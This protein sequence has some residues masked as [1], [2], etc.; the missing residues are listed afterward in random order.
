LRAPAALFKPTPAERNPLS[1]IALGQGGK[2]TLSSGVNTSPPPIAKGIST[3]CFIEMSVAVQCDFI[4]PPYSMIDPCLEITGVR[5]FLP[6][7]TGN[8]QQRQR[9]RTV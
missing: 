6:V 4:A 1:G 9:D 7:V 5:R 8:Q 2:F 3:R